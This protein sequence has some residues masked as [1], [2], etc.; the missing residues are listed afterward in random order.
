MRWVLL[1]LLSVPRAPAGGPDFGGDPPPP[2]IF[3]FWG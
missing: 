3:W 1:M 2:P